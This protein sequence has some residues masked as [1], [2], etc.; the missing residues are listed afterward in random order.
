MRARLLATLVV[1]MVL[2]LAVRASLVDTSMGPAPVVVE[3]FT[4]QGCSSCPPA[5]QLLREIASDRALRGKVIPLAFHVDYWNHLGWSDPF[6]SHAWTQRQM[7]YVG[8]MKLSSAY[9]PQAVVNGSVQLVGSRKGALSS[10]ISEGSRRATVGRVSVRAMRTGNG[11]SALVD[12]EA[13]AGYDVMVA[14]FQDGVT[15]SIGAGENGGRTQTEDAIV[16]RLQRVS[17][18]SVTLPVDPAWKDI[19]VA[20]FLQNRQTLAIGNAAVARVADPTF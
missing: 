8:S 11:V 5:D 15:T 12:A 19:G 16:R 17:G 2:G 9:T 3:L 20:V 7:A 10:A 13:P 14:L 18:E 1:L 4:S 6:S